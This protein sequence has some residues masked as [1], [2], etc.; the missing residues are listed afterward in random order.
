MR[1]DQ[2]KGG[3]MG[4]NADIDKAGRE[5]VVAILQGLKPVVVPL[6]VGGVIGAY[7]LT[8]GAFEMVKKKCSTPEQ[9]AA[10]DAVQAAASARPSARSIH[11]TDLT[12]LRDLSNTV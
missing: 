6:A 4:D 12:D 8:K 10:L 3:R 5:L 1:H 2:D 7:K 9:H 11:R